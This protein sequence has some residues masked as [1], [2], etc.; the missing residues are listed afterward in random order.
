[1]M[2]SSH[3]KQ[4]TRWKGN[5]IATTFIIIIIGIAQFIAPPPYD[6][7]QNTVS[8]LAAQ[9][10]ENKW[11]MQIGFIGF[12]LM[13]SITALSNLRWHIFAFLREIPLSVYALGIGLSGIFCTAPFRD[14]VL[15][16]SAEAELH[17]NFA[18]LAG[19]AFSVTLTAHMFTDP[20]MRRKWLHLIA[21]VCTVTIAV[22]FGM[23]DQHIG[24]IQRLLYLV[25]FTWIIFVYNSA[26]LTD[27]SYSQAHYRRRPST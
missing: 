15:Y 25:G 14:G 9:G 3:S 11:L 8:E 10:Y 27:R 17:S 4:P 6:W 2:T 24:I 5:V 16:S 13:L 26:L 23:S 1:M 22:T 7:T 20:S 12:G 18:T 21:L 19:A